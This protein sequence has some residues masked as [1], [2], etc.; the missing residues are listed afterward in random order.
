MWFIRISDH[1]RKQLLAMD[2]TTASLIIGYLKKN[3]EN[4]K[5]PR[6][7]GVPLKGKRQDQWRYLFGNYRILCSLENS[8]VVVYVINDSSSLNIH[9]ANL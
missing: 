7:F 3:I 6:R 4:H 2:R 5:D 8:L 1:A 9:K